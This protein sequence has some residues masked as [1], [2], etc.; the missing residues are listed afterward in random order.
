[1]V[2]RGPARLAALT[3]AIKRLNG[4]R[5]HGGACHQMSHSA[6]A[7]NAAVRQLLAAYAM[8]WR[9]MTSADDLASCT[10]VWLKQEL[11]EERLLLQVLERLTPD[12]A[13][14]PARQLVNLMYNVAKGWQVRGEQQQQLDQQR[15]AF[16]A[17]ASRQVTQLA[18]DGKLNAQGL[19]NSLWAWAKLV[20]AGLPIGWV[21]RQLCSSFAAASNS[22]IRD[23]TAQALSNTLWAWAK[24]MQA[25]LRAQLNVQMCRSLAQQ[26]I[27]EADSFS[28]QALSNFLWAWASLARGGHGLPG[29]QDE[30][31]EE[32]FASLT[33]VAMQRMPQLNSQNM[34]NLLY[35]HAS[36]GRFSDPQLYQRLA[37]A[38]QGKLAGADEQHITNAAWAIAAACALDACSFDATAGFWA[39]AAAELQQ[40]HA[41]QPGG[42]SSEDLAQLYQVQR[43]AQLLGAGHRFSLPPG[44]S[45]AAERCF[46]RSPNHSKPISRFQSDVTRIAR[47]LVQ[48]SEITAAAAVPELADPRYPSPI[49][50][51]LPWRGCPV[52]LQAD[53]P[54]HFLLDGQ[55]QPCCP[56]GRTQLRDAI[57]RRLG[58]LVVV[59]PAHQWDRLGDDAAKEAYLRCRL[60]AS[61]GGR[62]AQWLSRP[63]V[64]AAL[65]VLHTGLPGE[66]AL[67]HWLRWPCS[68]ALSQRIAARLCARLCLHWPCLCCGLHW[69]WAAGVSYAVPAAVAAVAAAASRQLVARRAHRLAPTLSPAAGAT[70]A[71]GQQQDLHLEQERL[72]AAQQRGEQ[73]QAASSTSGRVQEGPELPGAPAAAQL[74]SRPAKPAA[75]SR[76]AAVGSKLGRSAS[77]SSSSSSSRGTGPSPGAKEASASSRRPAH[78]SS[79]SS[80]P[81]RRGSAAVQQ[82][83]P[84]AG[85]STSAPAPKRRTRAASGAAGDSSADVASSSSSSS[86]SS[87][88]AAPSK[89]RKPLPGSSRAAE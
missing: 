89:R 5:K 63:Q 7:Q 27:A 82:P 14:M 17:A 78:G 41:Q 25:K 26:A 62:P 1:V 42:F 43:V 51:A 69:I 33:E 10:S 6:F 80:S 16:F 81:D 77:K 45:A 18:T 4:L 3:R 30:L 13:Q 59:V 52:A 57:L 53:G 49:D 60:D 40:R 76:P 22:R 32:L 70:S 73:Q 75:P 34:A 87:S 50:C 2:R 15:A 23:F 71:A 37:E 65:R 56:D 12:V 21:D 88:S 55:E 35:A 66:L 74:P 58:W 64:L 67:G 86:N 84:A 54:T 47:R 79:L 38:M 46:R 19:S 36:C 61:A 39:A 72:M 31:V 20:E 24:L 9:D 8:M 85:R 44:L 28:P 11:L 29:A 48:S 68:N 83:E